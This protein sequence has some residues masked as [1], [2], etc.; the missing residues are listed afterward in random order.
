MQTYAL[1]AAVMLSGP[2]LPQSAASL[3]P[4]THSC[5][6]GAGNWTRHFVHASAC[7]EAPPLNLS[8][9]PKYLVSSRKTASPPTSAT[10]SPIKDQHRPP[11]LCGLGDCATAQFTNPFA[12]A[13]QTYALIAAVML[14]GP[15]LPQS[16][17]SL[18]PATHSCGTGAGNWTRHFVHAS[19]C[20]EAP[21]LNLSCP[22]K[23]L[24]SSRKTA[25]PPTS[26]TASPIKDQHRP[27]ALCGLG[28]CATAQFTNP[29]AFAMQVISH[30]PCL[31]SCPSTFP[32]R[33]FCC[34]IFSSCSKRLE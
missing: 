28:D 2:V 23:Y 33:Y 19:A 27:P 14:S 25:S 8:C 20:M 15:V 26:A 17:A 22:P 29:F 16:A 6:T 30:W 11:A 4:A 1:I 7:M 9:P 24:V 3:I 5:G 13:M 10:A 32:H 34:L 18:I 31:S 21:P 12:F